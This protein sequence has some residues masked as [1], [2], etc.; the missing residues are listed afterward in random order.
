M[1]YSGKMEVRW[2]GPYPPIRHADPVTVDDIIRLR[3]END[4][5]RVALSRIRDFVQ[6]PL[7][8]DNPHIL[9]YMQCAKIADE[10]LNP[11]QL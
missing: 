7:I 6:D 9:A 1:N 4:R 5:M 2:L 3:K 10:A 11:K 8:D